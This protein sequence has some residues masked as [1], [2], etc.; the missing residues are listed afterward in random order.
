MAS[1]EKP[2]SRPDGEQKPTAPS[3]SLPKG[4]GAIRG[5]GEKFAAN[6]VTGT[7][8]MSVPIATSPGR[9]GFGR[10]LSL[11]YDSGAGNGPFGFGWN[12]SLPAIT[13]KTDKGL[14]QYR[15]AEESDVFIL[16][17][18][19]DL[20]PVLGPDGTRF[21][22]IRAHPGLRR[23][24]A[25]ARGSRACSPASS[26]G[27]DLA[28]GEI[29][30][31]SITRDNVTT[32]Y[33]KDA[34]SRIADPGRPAAHL[35]LADLRELRRQGQRHRLRVRGRERRRRRSARRPTSATARPHGQ[36]LPEAHQVRQPR[37]APGRS[38]T[39]TQ[40]DW[41][42]EVVFD[43]DE[44]HYEEIALDPADLQTSS[45]GSSAQSAPAGRPWAV[46][47]DPF[48]SYRAGFEVRTYR[49]C[50]RVLM[51]HHFPTSSGDE[52]TAWCA[53]PS[54]TTPIS[55]TRSRHDRGRARPSGQHPLRL[56]HSR[57]H[58]V[59]LRPRRHPGRRGAQRR[60]YVTYLKKSLPPLEFEYSK[61]S[62]PG[63][64]PRARRRRASRTCP[65]ASTAPTYQWVDLDGE[66]ISGILTEQAGAWFY[67]PNLGDGRVRAARRRVAAQALAGG[68][69]RRA[70]AA[71]RP[72]R[73]RPARPGRAST[74]RRPGFYERDRRRGLG[75]VPRR[76]A[77]CP[78][79][80][81][82]DPNLRFVD[83]DGD[84]HADV[85]ITEDDVFTW[86]PSLAEDGFGPAAARA[87]GARRG[88]GPA[89]WSSPTA[90]SRS[91]SPTCRGDGL[92]DLV[93]IRNGEVCYWPNL[94][95]GRFGAKVTM[96]NAPWFDDPDQF[97]QRRIR[98]A[99]IDG[100]GT[101]DII[102]LRPRRRAP[103]L[104]PV[105]Q[106]LER[107]ATPR[108]SSRASTT[109]SSVTAVDLLGNGTACLVWSS[110]LPGDARRPMR[111][112][113][114]MGGQQAAPADQVGQQPRRRDARPL[115]AVDPVLPGRTSATAGPG[116][117]GCRS[118]C[119]SSSASRPT[120]TS[121]ATASS[122]A[123]PTTTAT[124][125]AS[126]AS[127]AASA[128]SSSGTPRSSRRSPPAAALAGRPTSTPPRTCRR[129]S[130][131]PG[132]TPASTSAATTSPTSSPAC[133]TRSD[134]GEYYREPGLTD[135]EARALLLDDTV[136]PAGLTLEEE[137]EACRALKGSM[138]R[139]EV[140]ALD[141]TDEAPH[142]YTVTEQNF[143]IRR[144]AAARRQPPRRVLHPP[145]RGASATTTSAT[146]PIRASAT[147]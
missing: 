74:A 95:Y 36:P 101:T 122:P 60:Q 26:A 8:S 75:A 139:Q 104:Q 133:S 21:R 66:G 67:K 116:S 145:A 119:T 76:S 17:G 135:A 103:L 62:H 137:R 142:P 97:D 18:A 39:S 56:V 125:T 131:R 40:A 41:M 92:T 109:S 124:S 143:T 3:I 52:P 4:G 72:G 128:W 114:L 87:P 147:R 77:S 6:P 30:W 68:A 132:S 130:P 59:G 61:A 42:F 85:L 80:R 2:T 73:R 89:R 146:R 16:S 110:P 45:I 25:T 82:D 93:R 12:L 24:I 144:A 120:T 134:A 84:G 102:Y 47:P 28:T 1:A 138:L 121:A 15:D 55:T 9:S 20:V 33:G 98:L 31:R 32:L 50:Q 115:R 141:G 107:A 64:G 49:R 106:P 117:R 38:R 79:S 96:D 86:H 100:S 43:Y 108:R 112:V 99:D 136:L 37:L 53:P 113:D 140:Y 65:R 111:Y 83:L 11:S 123:T 91:T 46:R 7:G 34:E 10:Q 69:E 5:I 54:S 44:G 88:E 23:S 51:F 58:P 78:T 90:R 127:S 70:P 48:S 81:W 63:R 27:P 22:A 57:R 126:S 19:E 35:Q 129:C 13:R 71:P 94:G 29:H 105:G 14:P 118:R